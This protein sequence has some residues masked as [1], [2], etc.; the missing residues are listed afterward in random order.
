MSVL[1]TLGAYA[2]NNAMSEYHANKS[3]ERS[4]LLMDKQNAMNQANA[5]T[6]YS[7]QVQGLRMAGLNPALAQNLGN[8]PVQNVSQ[9]TGAKGENVEM[10]PQDLL[11]KAQIDNMQ[12]QTNKVK[13][14]TDQ[15][16]KVN[17]IT[18]TANN[19]AK[20]T[21]LEHLDRQIA[22]LT[23]EASKHPKGSNE[24]ER[25]MDRIDQLNASKERVNDPA[26]VGALGIA[27]G[28]KSGADSV[29]SDFDVINGFLNGK[30]DKKVLVKKNM[31]SGV[32]DALA[33]MPKFQKEHLAQSIEQIKQAIAE[34]ESKEELN[35]QTVLK[36]QKEISNIGNEMLHR[37]LN[38]PVWIRTNLG[39]DSKEWKAWTDQQWRDNAFK[40]GS[41]VLQGIAT[42]G[43]LGAVNKFLN[44]ATS[45]DTKSSGSSW[46]SDAQRSNPIYGPNGEVVREGGTMHT[47]YNSANSSSV[48]NFKFR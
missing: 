18:D 46:Q 14:E 32:V 24:Y 47:F 5:L 8:A 25:L 10:S 35:D 29:K 28:L 27:Q 30:L 7:N 36:I 37:N 16:H 31:D 20:A 41:S 11:L 12:A 45:K 15:I 23:D 1:A 22:D 21:Y 42:G 26:F 9:G 17:D 2:V 39:K 43:A 6:A 19:S 33:S 4:R 40:V 48:S 13:E 3:D 34:S 44:T 38:D